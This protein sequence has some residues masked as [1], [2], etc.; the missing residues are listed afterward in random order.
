[1]N[2]TMTSLIAL[3]IGTMAYNMSKGKNIVSPRTMKKM[4]KRVMKTFS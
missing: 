2:K 4:R 1:M 3:G